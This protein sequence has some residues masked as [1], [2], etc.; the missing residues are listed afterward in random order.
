MIIAKMR[1]KKEPRK[2]TKYEKRSADLFFVT[3]L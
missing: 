2:I 3:P 1:T